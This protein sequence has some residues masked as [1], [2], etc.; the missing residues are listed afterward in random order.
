MARAEGLAFHVFKPLHVVQPFALL[1]P[2]AHGL[3]LERLRYPF[4]TTTAGAIRAFSVGP[5]TVLAARA[6]ACRLHV[7]CAWQLALHF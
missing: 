4:C 2:T 1:E 3:G 5:A 7:A 6:P